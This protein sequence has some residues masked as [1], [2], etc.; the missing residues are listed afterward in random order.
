MLPYLLVSITKWVFGRRELTFLLHIFL[1]RYLTKLF[2]FFYFTKNTLLIFR[3]GWEIK[4][5]ES[6]VTC[7]QVWSRV[8]TIYR[9]DG[10]PRYKQ[11]IIILC[12]F[13]YL[14]YLEKI[15]DAESHLRLGNNFPLNCSLAP[16][17]RTEETTS[18]TEAVISNLYSTSKYKLKLAVW[19]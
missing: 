2:M 8:V 12:T 15:K 16:P 1:P 17:T 7:S 10:I 11:T 4:Q 9:C 14:R 13:A 18:E 6:D 19:E 3:E 5:S